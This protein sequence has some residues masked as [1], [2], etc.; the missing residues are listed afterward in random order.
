MPVITRLVA[1]QKNQRRVNLYLDGQFAFALSLDE[2]VKRGLKKGLE[3][4]EDTIDG[5]KAR[6]ADDYLYAKLLNFLSYR[7]RSTKEL[8]DRLYRYEVKD[9]AKQD[10]F[11]ARLT[12]QGY[13][14]D[15]A[16]ARW[17]IASRNTHRPRSV[18]QLTA[19]L[20]KKG[21][22]REIIAA[23]SGDFA[24]EESTLRSL[25][26]KKLGRPRVLTLRE[27]QQIYIYLA[28]R[29]FAW[30]KLREVVKNWETE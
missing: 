10:S 6:D 15:L 24:K 23:A 14:D 13:L 29:G 27:R 11:I 3:L 19:E 18:R 4:A 25:L 28:R 1:G 21:V 9:P 2:I 12:T 26:G 8:R 20:Q 5:L 7:P 17:F 16:F 22:S 30:D